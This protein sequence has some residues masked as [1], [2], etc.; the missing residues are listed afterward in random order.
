MKV[1]V[2]RRCRHT[3]AAVPLR[4]SATGK[5]RKYRQEM[6]TS[7]V[8]VSKEAQWGE[9]GTETLDTIIHS[10][11]QRKDDFTKT[12]G[13]QQGLLAW[14]ACVTNLRGGSSAGPVDFLLLISHLRFST[15]VWSDLIKCYNM[16][17]GTTLRN[18]G[19]FPNAAL[20]LGRLGVKSG[21]RRKS[22]GGI[23]KVRAALNV[24]WPPRS[25]LLCICHQTK[26]RFFL[27][28]R[29]VVRTWPESLNV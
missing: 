22:G 20:A 28:W 24:S 4:S 13:S 7:V 6:A 2:E 15:F 10:G 8:T 21:Q 1:V 11:T 29:L 5:R 9:S 25:D 23:K 19:R 27:K 18:G 17:S 26:S 12:W 3:Q 16:C 14:V